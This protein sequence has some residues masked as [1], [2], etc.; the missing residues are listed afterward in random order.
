MAWKIITLLTNSIIIKESPDLEDDNFNDLL[1]L[2]TAI[3]HLKQIG[4]LTE[5]EYKVLNTLKEK[6]NIIDVSKELKISK[7]LT[8][9][10]LSSGAK[11]LEFYLAG[12]FSDDG[13][14]DSLIEKEHLSEDQVKTLKTFL[15]KF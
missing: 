13:M 6:A 11:K 4:S 8:F 2:E 3:E 12:S 5:L 10:T 1:V 15:E 14:L 9:N 7:F